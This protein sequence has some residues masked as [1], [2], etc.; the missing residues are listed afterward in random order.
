LTQVP[1]HASW[2]VLH[3]EFVVPVPLA[4]PAMRISAVRKAVA[5]DGKRGLRSFMIDSF[6]EDF[7]G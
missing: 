4:Q 5:S 3:C 7:P 6:G 1:L 2:F